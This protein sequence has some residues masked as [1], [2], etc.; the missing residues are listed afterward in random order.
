LP[1]SSTQTSQKNKIW[2]LVPAAGIGTRMGA[3]IPKQY[4]KLHGK[5]VLAWTLEVLL[6]LEF[7]EKI[8]LILHPED[9]YFSEKMAA[10][11]PAVLQ[12]KGG[13]ERQHSVSNG[14]E[15]LK[16]LAADDD[17]VLVHDAA[18][19]CVKADDIYKLVQELQDDAVGGILASRVK[20]TLKHADD[21]QQVL[22]T[23]DRNDYWLAATP[24]LF[25]FKLLMDA[26]NNVKKSKKIA[27]DEAVAI[28]A[29]GQPVKLI[30]GHRD[31]IKITSSED[32]AL[33]EFLL[34]Q[35]GRADV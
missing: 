7:L 31:N 19:P 34:E 14:L 33:A 35:T 5:A 8:V 2:A 27:T 21:S 13:E 1:D 30:E 25:R 10:D 28:E 9:T 18:R 29:M 20:D 11:F 3:G 26:L 23:V 32:L 22:S 4:I 17:W 6:G 15:F 16:T 24:Q 12:V